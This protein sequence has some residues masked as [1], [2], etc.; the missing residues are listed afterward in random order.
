MPVQPGRVVGGDGDRGHQRERGR[1][2]G[3]GAGGGAA[4]L[5]AFQVASPFIIQA[6]GEAAVRIGMVDPITGVYAALAQGEVSRDHVDVAVSTLARIPKVLKNKVASPF[7]ETENM[8]DG[9]DAVADWPLLNALLNCASGA[10][11]TSSITPRFA[12]IRRACV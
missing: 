5:G 11:C 3:E 10:P 9:S 8:K 6:R 12:K 2:H 4:A 1:P 7:R